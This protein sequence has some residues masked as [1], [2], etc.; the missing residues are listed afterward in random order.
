MNCLKDW[1]WYL[2]PTTVP[3]LA[4]GS[5]ESSATPAEC[6]YPWTFAVLTINH[7]QRL[8][9]WLTSTSKVYRGFQSTLAA[10]FGSSLYLCEVGRIAQWFLLFPPGHQG[11]QRADMLSVIGQMIDSQDL[12]V[13][14][15]S[16]NSRYPELVSKR[17]VFRFRYYCPLPTTSYHEWMFKQQ[18]AVGWFLVMINCVPWLLW[19]KVEEL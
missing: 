2:L 16:L 12:N 6:L 9:F 5:T 7:H 8:S 1:L 18:T 10:V 19:I 11:S 14:L 4:L 13:G 17:S 3:I 15:L